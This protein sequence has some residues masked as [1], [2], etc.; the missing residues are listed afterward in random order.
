MK[1]RA[2]ILHQK[3]RK[4]VSVLTIGAIFSLFLFVVT[5][6]IMAGEVTPTT[7]TI[8]WTSPGDNGTSGTATVYDIRYSSAPISSGNWNSCNQVTDE[9]IPQ[10]CG[11]LENFTITALDPDTWY[12]IAIIAADEASNWSELSNVIAVK[13]Q[14]LALD[15]ETDEYN[16]PEDFRLAQNFPNP[17]NPSTK[18]EFSI[19]ITAHV[20]ISI[21]NILGQ[22]TATLIDEIKPAGNYTIIWNGADS[23]GQKV[24]SGIYIYRII[25]NDYTESKKMALVQ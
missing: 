8:T 21:Y 14:S 1:K 23:F 18:I 3:I 7:I 12:Y 24:S 17:F 5:E 4:I 9:P 15:V 25:A 16:I 11:S 13:T 6:P 22:E 10:Q 20:T 2:Y 19:P